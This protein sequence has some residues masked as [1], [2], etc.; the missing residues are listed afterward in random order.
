MLR[1]W[2]G[3]LELIKPEAIVRGAGM[4][5]SLG[6]ALFFVGSA[7]GIYGAVIWHFRDPIEPGEKRWQ[8]RVGVDVGAPVLCVLGLLSALV[9]GIGW[10][11]LHF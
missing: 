3:I 7:L 8:T 10:L 1:T 11:L 5:E 9:G 4:T 6:S 2:L